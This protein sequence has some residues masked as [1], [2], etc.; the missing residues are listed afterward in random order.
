MKGIQVENKVFKVYINKYGCNKVTINDGTN[1]Y[2]F[3]PQEPQF[4]ADIPE[5]KIL[6]RLCMR[7]PFLAIAK[8][9]NA[10]EVLSFIMDP[11]NR[12]SA[13]R[14]IDPNSD[15]A[16]INKYKPEDD[17]VI[18]AHLRKNGY[19]VKRLSEF[20]DQILEIETAKKVMEAHGYSF[21]KKPD[22]A[23][24]IVATEQGP[25]PIK[26]NIPK[27]GGW[28]NN[29][30]ESDRTKSKLKAYDKAE[31]EK[32]DRAEL[33]AVAKSKGIN[34]FAKSNEALIKLIMEAKA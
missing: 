3:R 33:N 5:N 11:K 19:D 8:D 34:S 2:L 18:I 30:V 22:A 29:A 12:P 13:L 25:L 26:E 9:M 16:N 17:E 14:L 23:P 20:D 1:Q 27:R 32:L 10:V 24:D 7:H 6:I 15:T 28:A 4:I 31:L 21:Q